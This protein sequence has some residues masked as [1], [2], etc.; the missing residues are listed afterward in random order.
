MTFEKSIN[1]LLADDDRA[2]LNDNSLDQ[3]TFL[4]SHREE[5]LFF[6]GYFGDFGFSGFRVFRKI[7]L[8]S[9]QHRA[10]GSSEQT[11]FFV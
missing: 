10:A 6:P 4:R 1:L 3:R 11:A 7:R 8:A 5:A 9:E 2:E